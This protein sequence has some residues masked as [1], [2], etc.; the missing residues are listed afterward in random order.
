[1]RQIIKEVRIKLVEYAVDSN[2]RYPISY[3]QDYNGIIQKN[4]IIITNPTDFSNNVIVLSKLSLD[5]ITVSLS[6]GFIEIFS[7]NFFF[8]KFDQCSQTLKTKS[9]SYFGEEKLT[10]IKIANGTLGIDT[11]NNLIWTDLSKEISIKSTIVV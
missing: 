2:N 8:L 7:D 4:N 9:F 6:C 11:S 3:S 10:N 1:M 5:F